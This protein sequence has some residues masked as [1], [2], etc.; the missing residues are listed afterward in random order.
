MDP[1]GVL[2]GD[3]KIPSRQILEVCVVVPKKLELMA[4]MQHRRL[5][6]DP[7]D[8]YDLIMVAIDKI[9]YVLQ[10]IQ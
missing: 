6:A 4:F 9:Q 8:L 7:A 10:T 1:Q 5:Q 3:Q 2:Q